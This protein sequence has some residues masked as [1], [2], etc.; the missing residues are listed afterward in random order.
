MVTAGCWLRA[1]HR[2]ARNVAGGVVAAAL[3]ASAAAQGLTTV[4]FDS[5]RAGPFSSYIEDGFVVTA[6]T[7]NWKRDRNQVLNGT[8]DYW[9]AVSNRGVAELS[10]THGG[11]L[12]QFTSVGLYSLVTTI[13]YEIR[14]YRAGQLVFERAAAEP[15]G[16]SSFVQV[17][18]SSSAFVDQ[19]TVRLTNTVAFNDMGLDNLSFNVVSVV[20]EPPVW[21]LGVAGVAV[22]V[23]RRS[24]RN[25]RAGAQPGARV[26]QP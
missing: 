16:Q 18:S 23:G 8:T 21:L 10:V 17:A 3:A 25:R 12:F 15:R 4:S 11:D 19:L 1:G 7:S 24:A 22:L 2:V 20:P 5:L 26:R 9:L 13:P 6:L 14:G